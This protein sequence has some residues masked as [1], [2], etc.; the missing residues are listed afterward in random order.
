MWTLSLC[1]I[2]LYDI[3]ICI[4]IFSYSVFIDYKFIVTGFKIPKG[5]QI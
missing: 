5:H 4:Y 2:Y 1:N 3:Y